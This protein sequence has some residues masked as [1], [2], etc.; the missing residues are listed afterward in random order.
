MYIIC[1]SY[2]QVHSLPLDVFLPEISRHCAL[3]RNLSE[4]EEREGLVY[5]LLESN[6]VHHPNE[7][8]VFWCLF[9]VSQALY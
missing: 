8:R 9:L 5:Y 3:A 7:I 2:G 6:G 1:H 4:L